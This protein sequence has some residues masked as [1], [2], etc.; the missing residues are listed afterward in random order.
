MSWQPVGTGEQL[1]AGEE[2]RVRL[3]IRAPYTALVTGGLSAAFKAHAFVSN[4]AIVR[5][6]HA[7]PAFSPHGGLQPFPFNVVFRVR[8]A[9]G[10]TEAGVDPKAAY[11]LA[12]LVATTLF[13]FAIVSKK[14]ER[15]VTVAGREARDL[16]REVLNPG[17]VIL[18]FVVALMVFQRGR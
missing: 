11:A 7:P 16:A 10:I 2:Y 14:L 8:H 18:A 15:F 1:V 13:A 17:F 6:E 5:I 4:L 9:P 12:V 3:L